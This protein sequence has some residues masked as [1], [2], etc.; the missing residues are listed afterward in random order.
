MLAV[1]AEAKKRKKETGVLWTV[2]HIV[3]LMSPLVC[4]LHVEYNLQLLTHAENASKLNRRWP[5]MPGDENGP[6]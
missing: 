1:Y 3:P 6:G 5:D 4:G 2:D